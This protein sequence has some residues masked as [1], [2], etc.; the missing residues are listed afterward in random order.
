MPPTQ[1]YLTELARYYA[2]TTS[3]E[4]SY[5][6]PLQTYLE[7]IFPKDERFHIQHDARSVAG[8]KPDFI[9]LRDGVPLL[10]IEVKKPGE[11]LDKLERSSQAA[12]YFGYT[13]LVLS[14]Y[15]EFRFYR[16]GERYDEPISLATVDATNKTLAQHPEQGKRLRHTLRDFIESQKEPIT[17]GAHLAKIM[18]GKAQRIRDN[19]IAFLESESTQ[20]DELEKMRRFIRDHLISDFTT[21]DFADMYAQTL[22]YGLFAAR[23]N[24]ETLD[25]FSRQEARDLVPTTNP[26]LRQ[27]FEHIGGAGFPTR[28][29]LIVDELCAV[30]AHADVRALMEEYFK[31][32]KLDGGFEESPDPVIHFY[33]D[34]LREYD[35]TK[36]MEMGVFYTPLPVVRFIV[37]GIDQ[38]LGR[39]FGIERGLADTS[40]VPVTT[41]TTDDRGKAHKETNE[42]HRVQLL[43]VAV[44]TGTFLNETVRHVHTAEAH[45]QGRW[46]AYVNEHLLPRLHGFEL[47]MASYTIAHL[48]LAMTLRHTGAQKLSTRLGVYL[49]NTL[50]E[51]HNVPLTDSLFGV[52]GSIAEE[53]KLAA[54]VKR[55]RPIMV[56]MGN[57]R[58]RAS[59]KTN[60]TP[61]ITPTKSNPVV[62]KNYKS[63]NTGSTTTT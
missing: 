22:V 2:D 43:D 11:D 59:H 3:S 19:V 5:R 61:R 9:V 4:Y 35:P 39:E 47:M 63:V 41:T 62:N 32:L 12:R 38:L 23:Y 13:N 58:T 26:F 48:K 60:T 37:R 30:F 56:V 28:L 14:D 46:E 15:A 57:P 42:L 36:K 20:R 16:N 24:D 6:T 51:P 31:Q 44:G 40:T 29:E 1:T 54:E 7:A 18:G 10:Y 34:F 50:D 45:N 52:T 21:E 25:T 49:S 53:S 33:E 8:N 55:E 27:F 17:H